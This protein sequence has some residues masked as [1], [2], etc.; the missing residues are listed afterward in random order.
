MPSPL[1]SSNTFPL[2]HICFSGSSLLWRPQLAWWK[3]GNFAAKKCVFCPR[4]IMQSVQARYLKK[5]FPS[6]FLRI[7]LKDWEYRGAVQVIGQFPILAGSAP[8]GWGAEAGDFLC[9][10]LGHWTLPSIAL[11]THEL[12]L[13]GLTRPQ[14]FLCHKASFLIFATSFPLLNFSD[15][16]FKSFHRY[17]AWFRRAPKTTWWSIMVHSRWIFQNGVIAKV[18]HTC[19]SALTESIQGIWP[20]FPVPKPSEHMTRK[21]RS[22]IRLWLTHTWMEPRWGLSV[23]RSFSC[24]THRPTCIV[25][26]DHPKF[27]AILAFWC[28]A[29]TVIFRYLRRTICAF[30]PIV[31]MS[32]PE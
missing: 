28:L 9:L 14:C 15:S 27:L 2:I 22:Q 10:S 30:D 7:T 18:V 21:K 16:S 3:V 31:S 19:V 4:R 17:P 23:T 11:S 1:F 32:S 12:F 6:Y 25:D 20:P 29:V 13:F 5:F 8:G 24:Q 26:I